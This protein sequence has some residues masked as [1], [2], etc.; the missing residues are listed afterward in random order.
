MNKKYERYI[1][2]IV[3]HIE[4]P[5]FINME[6]DYGLSEKEYELV[7]SKIFNQ[8]VTMSGNRVYNSNGNE[9]YYENSNGD[10]DKNEYD[11]NGNLIYREDSTGYWIKTEYD[12]NGNEI[13]YE[14]SDGV[15]EDNR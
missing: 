7:L 2:Y 8:P 4:P 12:T 1:N 14:N 13:Y 11:T 10:W 5:Y 6:R 9:I 3:N 15:I